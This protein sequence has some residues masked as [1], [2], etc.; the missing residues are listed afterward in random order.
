[1][2]IGSYSLVACS[3][4]LFAVGCNNEPPAP[5]GAGPAPAFEPYGDATPDPEG[6]ETMDPA[7]HPDPLDPNPA[8]VV[9]DTAGEDPTQPGG[10]LPPEP[11]DD[12]QSSTQ[13]PVEGKSRYTDAEPQE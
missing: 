7:T 3:L 10:L 4:A 5:E 12:S 11:E 8:P 1:M 6:T 9:P 2:K 13:P